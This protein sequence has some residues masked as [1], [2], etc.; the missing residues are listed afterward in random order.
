MTRN[1]V[2]KGRLLSFEPEEEAVEYTWPDCWTDTG[3]E[4]GVRFD[5]EDSRTIQ[6]VCDVLTNWSKSL[7]I[8][9][10]H[11]DALK[12]AGETFA[13]TYLSKGETNDGYP[14]IFLKVFDKLFEEGYSVYAS[15]TRIEIYSEL[16]DLP[17]GSALRALR[18][19][20][21]VFWND[22]DRGCSSGKYAITCINT[23][24]GNVEN[25]DDMVCLKSAAGSEAEVFAQE[26]TV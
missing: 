19:G 21:V 23:E 20:D 10:I 22:P 25:L 8:P 16:G 17:E 24:G 11:P 6:I 2:V 13:E 14:A 15:D 12:E 3:D 1:N 18:V 5:W 26:L 9:A 7:G 4:D